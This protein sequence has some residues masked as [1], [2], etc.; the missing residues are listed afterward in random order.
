MNLKSGNLVTLRKF[1][2]STKKPIDLVEVYTSPAEYD[3][4]L[5]KQGEVGI[6]L[7]MEDPIDCCSHAEMARVFHNGRI[8]WI[9]E[10]F[11]KKL[12]NDAPFSQV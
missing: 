10:D 8:G 9:Y 4:W 1:N 11:L 3:F 7:E 2:L 6:F 12:V 5:W